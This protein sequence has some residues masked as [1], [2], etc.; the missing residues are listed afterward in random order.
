MDAKDEMNAK[1]TT[2]KAQFERM[3]MEIGEVKKRLNTQ[4]KELTVIQKTIT[5]TE[6]R[7]EQ[8]R[9]DRHSLLQQCKVCGVIQQ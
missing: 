4:L 3:D 8:K 7:L 1:K 2:L 9:T 5:A 6:N